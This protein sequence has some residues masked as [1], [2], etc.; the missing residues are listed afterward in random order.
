MGKEWRVSIQAA[1]P[2]GACGAAVGG[3]RVSSRHIGW[4]IA[5]QIIRVQT[6][7]IAY[8]DAIE[9]NLGI[10]HVF[11][12]SPINPIPHNPHPRN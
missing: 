3:S 6:V 8:T 10:N 2:L 9:Q 7:T 4:N 1:D 5:F 12:V 11:D